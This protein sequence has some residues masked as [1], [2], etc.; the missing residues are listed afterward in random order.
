MQ[1]YSFSASKVSGGGKNQQ[2]SKLARNEE[3][4]PRLP[5]FARRAT[6][7]SVTFL[8][9][10]PLVGPKGIGEG[11]SPT[12][13]QGPSQ[14]TSLKMMGKKHQRRKQDFISQVFLNTTLCLHIRRKRWDS[15]KLVLRHQ[16][17][18]Y[19]FLHYTHDRL[20]NEHKFQSQIFKIELPQQKQHHKHGET[21]FNFSFTLIQIW[22]H[23][24]SK[25]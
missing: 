6:Y 3:P 21:Y 2:S 11:E 5:C 18:P 13:S 8:H 20:L 25:D 10:L 22:F 23:N 19:L 24:N 4:P 17:L 14:E 12:T 1:S 9:K 7:S 16:F 15:L